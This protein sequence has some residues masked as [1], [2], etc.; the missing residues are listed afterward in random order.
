MSDH[1]FYCRIIII[2]II[3][4]ITLIIIPVM[5]GSSV[6]PSFTVLERS[7]VL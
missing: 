3:I 4:V 2:I 7:K 1:I 6:P 5:D